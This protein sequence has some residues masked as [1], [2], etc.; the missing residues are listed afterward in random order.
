MGTS[1]ALE[2]APLERY[3]KHEA[4]LPKLFA[5]N[6]AET[7]NFQFKKLLTQN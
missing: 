6:I 7:M 1:H 3:V 2:R 4:L 5:L